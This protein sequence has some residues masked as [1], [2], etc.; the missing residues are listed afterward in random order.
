[1]PLTPGQRVGPFEI[2]QRLGAGGM[3]TVYLAYDTRLD[4]RIALKELRTPPGQVP[5]TQLLREARA[6][7]R[8]SHA[9]IATLHDAIE[10][11]GMALLVMQFVEGESLGAVCARGPLEIDRVVDIGIELADAL[12]HAH[13]QGIIHADIKPGNV[14]LGPDGHV[15]LLDLGIARVWTADPAAPTRTSTSDPEGVGPG[16]PA[17]MAPEQLTGQPADTRSDIYSLGALLFELATGRRAYEVDHV[18]ALAMAIAS[19]LLPRVSR[20]RPDVPPA[21]D[22]LIARTMARDPGARFQSAAALRE[23]L[24][25]V[26][27]R[28]RD[29]VA[30]TGG[31]APG[32]TD[33]RI[34]DAGY[35]TPAPAPARWRVPVFAGAGVVAAVLISVFAYMWSRP[36]SDNRPATPIAVL[37]AINLA[38]EPAT[39]ELGSSLVAILTSNLSAVQGVTVVSHA[40][41]TGFLNP[42]RNVD[43]IARELGAGYVVDLAIGRRGDLLR[44]TGRLTSPGVRDAIWQDTVEG[45]ALAIHRGVVDRVAVALER[46]GVF[47][48]ALTAADRARLRVLPTT[49]AQALVEYARGSAAL[50]RD[51]DAPGVQAAADAFASAIARDPSFALAHAGL[52]QA[53]AAMYT[54]TSDAVW[55]GRAASAAGRA[56]ELDP[57]QAPVHVSLARVYFT[58]GQLPDAER[59]ARVAVTLAPDSDDAHR[60]L[61]RILCE[62]GDIEAG[63]EEARTAVRLRPDYWVNSDSLGY[64]LY[65]AARYEDAIAPYR[66]VVTLRPG[67]PG[68]SGYV[69]LLW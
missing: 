25:E 23:A 29:P 39:G 47:R 11:D 24:I 28:S 40:T 17:Y 4:R 51:T 5:A 9:N 48:R 66:R 18:L 63:L 34:T 55:V 27:A 12:V 38:G 13:A 54:T 26:R 67:F 57:A 32:L 22:D 45:D 1:M 53:Y 15:K 16:T 10:I 56:L 7:A 33:P 20:L 49:D 58:E 60:L 31:P 42:D 59:H 68:G 69:I 30:Q 21:L 19:G 62:R 64:L 43:T 41:V 65:R 2:L 52:A 35:S 3:G 36:L 46:A 6:A 44:V 50:D 14:M 61:G 37:P 8:L